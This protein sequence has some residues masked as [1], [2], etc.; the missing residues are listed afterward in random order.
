MNSPTLTLDDLGQ[1]VVQ[2]GLDVYPQ[3]DIASERTRLN[4]FFEEIHNRWPDIY[5]K[6]VSSDTEFKVS[7]KF[8]AGGSDARGTA[9]GIPTETF[10]LVP[11]R[12]PVL[13]FPII[14]PVLGATGIEEGRCAEIF[15][16]VRT[17]FFEAIPNRKILRVGLVRTV[18]FDTGN[19]NCL[20]F[21]T[22]DTSFCG[23]RLMKGGLS[24]RFKD[25]K[26]NVSLDLQPMEKRSAAQLPIGA[27]VTEHQGYGLGVQL[28]VNNADPRPLEEP[29][30]QEVLERATGLW[31]VELLEYVR[32]LVGSSPA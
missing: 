14:L 10:A 2:F 27:R 15:S 16:A 19:D 30:I 17:L 12:G 32:T 11:R 23:A 9:P 6:L 1:H 22:S 8:Y 5:D 24:L 25:A 4:I 29:D 13:V 20:G 7:N 21:L 26:C 28:D 3:V 18:I 31:P